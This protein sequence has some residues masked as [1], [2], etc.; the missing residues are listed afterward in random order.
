[1]MVVLVVTWDFYSCCIRCKND[2]MSIFTFLSSVAVDA[3]GALS[4]CHVSGGIRLIADDVGEP[5]GEGAELLDGVIPGFKL[6]WCK[7]RQ[8]LPL[9]IDDLGAGTR[10]LNLCQLLIGTA[11]N[12]FHGACRKDC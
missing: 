6:I 5:N 1:M 3:N 11:L 10:L 2:E 4:S 12:V 8:H 9:R 7:I